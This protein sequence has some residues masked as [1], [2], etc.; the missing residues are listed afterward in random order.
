[1]PGN[2]LAVTTGEG[3]CYWHLVDEIQECCSAFYYAQNRPHNKEF[4][5]LNVNS[6]EAKKPAL[7]SPAPSTILLNE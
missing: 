6:A 5:D 2:I 1:M 3:G 4:Q 7:C